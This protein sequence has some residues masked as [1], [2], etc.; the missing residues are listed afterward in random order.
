MLRALF[1][2][3]VIA[4]LAVSP[5]LADTANLLGVF[6]NWETYTMGSGSQMSCFALSKPR[7][8]RPGSLK[9]AAAGLVVTDWPDRKVKAEPQI[10]PGYAYKAGT[11]VYLEIGGDKFAFFPR[12]DG[13][14]GTAWL[15]DLKDGG[16]LLNAL[17]QGVSAV[18]LGTSAR[19]TK[20]VDTY[21]LAGFSE[22]MAKIHAACNM[23]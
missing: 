9:R 23:G 11:P 17:N 4:A 19:G 21:A 10:V 1:L 5:A 18:A 12:N 16:A 3:S 7:A 8:V 14:N 15:K 6:K 13:A 2:G 20:T 22:A